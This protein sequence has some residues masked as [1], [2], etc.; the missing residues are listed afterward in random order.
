MQRAEELEQ[1]VNGVST[2]QLLATIDAVVK[3]PATAKFNFRAVNR[4]DNGGSNTTTVNEFDGAGQSFTRPEPFVLKI[5]E[6]HVLLGNDTSANPL[7]YLFA[8]LAG[9]LTTSL[10]YHAAAQGV[11]IDEIEST[12]SGD[13]DL[14]GFLGLD[15]NIRNGFENINVTFRVKG[16]APQEKLDELVELAQKRSG[17]FDTLTNGV[18]V[19]VT[20]A[21]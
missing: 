6:P 4:W 20:I 13:V 10:V 1:T 5:D 21:R 14:H 7:E 8:A 9:C 16:D 17:V 12:Y 3:E 18:P 15:E 2:T 19:K 11:R